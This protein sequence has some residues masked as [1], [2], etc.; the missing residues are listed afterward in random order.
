ME[1]SFATTMMQQRG[2]CPG[3]DNSE[4]CSNST[5]VYGKSLFQP[6]C[7][8]QKILTTI[9]KR[10]WQWNPERNLWHSNRVLLHKRVVSSRERQYCERVGESRWDD[11]VTNSLLVF[12]V[13]YSLFQRFVKCNIRYPSFGVVA[14]NVGTGPLVQFN[15]SDP[16]QK[17]KF[18]VQILSYFSSNFIWP[19]GVNLWTVGN[20]LNFTGI[21][22]ISQISKTGMVIAFLVQWDCNLDRSLE[23]CFPKYSLLRIDDPTSSSPGF[24]FRHVDKYYIQDPT[25]MQY[26]GIPA[27]IF[28]KK[29]FYFVFRWRRET[30]L[31]A[32][33]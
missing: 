6:L 9:T 7:L 2:T 22:N 32:G 5:C 11:C 12:P 4:L 3:N 31:R 30:S 21:S 18:Q 17:G 1:T 24:N 20:F 25:T 29:F 10:H 14:D 19:K 28:K 13:S 33:E 27:F 26:V 23:E 16:N 8:F 15:A